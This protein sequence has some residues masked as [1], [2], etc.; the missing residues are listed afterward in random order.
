MHRKKKDETA[1]LGLLEARAS[2]APCVPG[3]R[4][5]PW[6]YVKVLQTEYKTLQATQFADFVTG[7]FK[8][9]HFEVRYSYR[10]R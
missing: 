5:K 3:I 1:Q 10:I 8:T 6:D 4:D 7:H 9:S 2:T